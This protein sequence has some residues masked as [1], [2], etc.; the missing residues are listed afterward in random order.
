MDGERGPEA[1]RR[2]AQ[3]SDSMSE[4]MT[5]ASRVIFTSRIPARGVWSRIAKPECSEWYERQL[6]RKGEALASCSE[7]QSSSRRSGR[8]STLGCQRLDGIY[9]YVVADFCGKF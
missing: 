9:C 7:Y 3:V 6:T 8:R 4:P 1:R 5:E 2:E